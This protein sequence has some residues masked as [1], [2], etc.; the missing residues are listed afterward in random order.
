MRTTTGLLAAL[1]LGGACIFGAAPWVASAPAAVVAV[2]DEDTESVGKS[3][4]VIF[5]DGRTVTGTLLEETSTS[6]KVLVEQFGMSA[7]ATYD[8]GEILTV[9]RNAEAEGDGD[10]AEES[11]PLEPK[12]EAAADLGANAG[13]NKVYYFELEGGLGREMAVTPLRE[14]VEDVKSLQPDYLIIKVDMDFKIQNNDVKDYANFFDQF[15]TMRQMVPVLTDDIARDYSWKKKPKLVF[16]VRKAMGGVAF[17]PFVS[18]TIYYTSDA[19]QGGVGGLD[20]LFDGVGDEVV[21]QKQYSLRQGRA[22]GMANRGG[23]DPRII[24]AMTWAEYTLS[25]SLVG[26]KPVFYESSEGD[27]LLTDDGVDDR[28]DSMEDVVRG[29]G[30]DV[31]QLN[32]EL[33]YR[34]GISDGTADSL[35]EV[36]NQ[37]GI[38]RDSELVENR[39]KRILEDWAEGVDKG[40]RNFRRLVNDFQ[41]VAVEGDYQERTGARGLQM[42]LLRQMKG[43]LDRYGEA[44]DPREIGNLPDNWDQNIEIMI[45]RIRNA[46]QLD[47][48]P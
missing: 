46:Q 32:A 15:H 14:V 3:V 22:E 12:N 11:D 28:A 17:L 18:D 21:R 44:I 45:Q 29:R 10:G 1:M 20:H 40:E 27:H 43:I 26:G 34:L 5:H 8:K 7:E 38:A 42:R 41:R 47:G 30:N 37:L 35:D 2:Q 48:P 19:R 36:L 13:A 16:W 39:A 25:Y 6:V 4:T 24:K 9:E 31:L 33:A 23:H